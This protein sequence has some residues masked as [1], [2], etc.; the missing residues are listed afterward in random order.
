MRKGESVRWNDGN[1]ISVNVLV[2]IAFY[3][4]FF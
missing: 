3:L 2:G 4:K 1:K